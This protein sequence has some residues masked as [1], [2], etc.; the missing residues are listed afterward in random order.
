MLLVGGLEPP[1]LRQCWLRI[2][3][4]GHPLG[5]HAR[6]ALLV[7]HGELRSRFEHAEIHSIGSLLRVR[8]VIPSHRWS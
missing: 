8:L 4:A 2:L 1:L 6:V 7:E 5:H 3:T